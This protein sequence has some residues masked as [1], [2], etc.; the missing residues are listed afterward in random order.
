M[1]LCTCCLA[2]CVVCSLVAQVSAQTGAPGEVSVAVMDLTSMGGVSQDQMDALGDLLATEIGQL[3]GFRVIGKADI[4]AALRFEEHRLLL[5]CQDDTCISEIGGALG[6]QWILYG[7]VSQFG[8]SFLL[9]LKLMDVAITRVL[10]R[11]SQR[12]EGDPQALLRA[13]PGLIRKLLLQAEQAARPGGVSRL[14]AEESAARLDRWGHATFWPG[15]G[16]AAFGGVALWQASVAAD[17]YRLDGAS[18]AADRNAVWNGLAPAGFALGGALLLAGSVLWI[19]AARDADGGEPAGG[20]ALSAGPMVR[21]A[22]W[23][24]SL[25][26]R[27]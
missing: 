1:R 25:G 23:G 7:N 18:S 21:E 2:V 10:A 11:L 17:D 9:N 16:L 19:L 22:A 27:W 8:G 26:G 15:L 12:L 4:R 6:V 20:M 13:V 14:E 3:G 24:L 5:G